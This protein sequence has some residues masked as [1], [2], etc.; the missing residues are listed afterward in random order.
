MHCTHYITGAIYV[1]PIGQLHSLFK[2]HIVERVPSIGIIEAVLD[3]ECGMCARKRIEHFGRRNRKEASSLSRCRR[4]DNIK[5]DSK[6][7]AMMVRRELNRLRLGEGGNDFSSSIFEVKAFID[8]PSGYT[9]P[10]PP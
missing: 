8:Y 4:E 1:L 6:E 3:R 10:Q 9:A 2:V 5:T 7:D